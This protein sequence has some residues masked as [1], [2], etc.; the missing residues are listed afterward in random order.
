MISWGATGLTSSLPF[1]K[2]PFSPRAISK[3]R[4]PTNLL[5]F[6]LPGVSKNDVKIDLQDRTLRISGERKNE[7]TSGKGENLRTERYYG[8]IERAI[9]LPAHIKADSIE[10]QFED[11]VLHIAV[12][13]AEGVKP[14]QIQVTEGKPGLFSKLLGKKDEKVA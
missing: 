13:K 7:R 9:T 1:R 12:P 6:D 10:A 14:K 4:I 2:L 3:R 8:N 11:G 5:S